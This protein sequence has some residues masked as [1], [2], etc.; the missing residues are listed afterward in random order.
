MREGQLLTLQNKMDKMDKMD[1]VHYVDADV[2]TEIINFLVDI[3]FWLS[4]LLG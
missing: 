2:V 1:M 3:T 4:L